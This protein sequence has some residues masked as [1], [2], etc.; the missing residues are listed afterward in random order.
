MKEKLED[1]L[2]R[3]PDIKGNIWHPLKWAWQR[4]TRGWD[5]RVIWS[6]HSYLARMTPIWLRELKARKRGI[7]ISMFDDPNDASDASIEAA[8]KRWDEILDDMIAGFEAAKQIGGRHFAIYEEKCQL[9]QER[10]GK[11]LVPWN[12]ENRT[13]LDEL[14]EEIDFWAKHDAQY[15][16]AMGRFRKGMALF[17]EHFFSLWD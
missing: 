4:L 14:Y 17:T 11:I 5:D 15:D 2:Y 13:L 9:M 3:L 16:E 7:P 6:I 12:E 10:Y 1:L 8:A